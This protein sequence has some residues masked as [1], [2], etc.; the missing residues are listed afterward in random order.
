MAYIFGF[1][2]ADGNMAK[3]RNTISF[4]SKDYDLIIMIK[5]LLKSEHKISKYNNAFLLPITNKTI[6]NDLIKL[7]GIPAKSL[8]I[9][10]PEVPDK[11]LSHF[12]R[13]FLDD[14]GGFYIKKNGKYKYLTAAFTGNIDFLT[15]LKNKIK[16]NID[17]DSASFNISHRNEPNHNQRIYY[18]SYLNK[19]AIA[20]GDYLYQ[21]SENL[22][23]E[24]KFKIYEKMKEE[25]VKKLEG[26][27]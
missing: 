10:F 18:L 25:M 5:S 14:D 26:R 15:A 4:A 7:G 9:Q 27:I 17:I 12:I 6:Y 2:I 24:R 13:G 16:E 20:L 3:N 8:I 1:W 22:R 21:G 23:L 19:K 11:Y